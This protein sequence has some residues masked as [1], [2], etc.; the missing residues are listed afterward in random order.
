MASAVSNISMMLDLS[1]GSGGRKKRVAVENFKE[2][3]VCDSR[4]TK[5][6]YLPKA[7]NW[8]REGAFL[9]PTD[10]PGVNHVPLYVMSYPMSSDFTIPVFP[11][12][13]PPSVSSLSLRKLTSF[14]ISLA[15]TFICVS[16]S[17]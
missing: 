15:T 4:S 14:S 11:S 16:V 1:V 8:T 5:F 2:G 6:Q 13:L 17:L 10:Y 9:R 7:L 3:V 12:F